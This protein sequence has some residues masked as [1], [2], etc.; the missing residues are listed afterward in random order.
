MSWLVN[1]ASSN[2]AMR[3]C[4]CLNVHLL[5]RKPSWLSCSIWYFSPYDDNMEV[6]VLVNNL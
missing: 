1:L 4:S 2:A 5:A 3:S 6:S